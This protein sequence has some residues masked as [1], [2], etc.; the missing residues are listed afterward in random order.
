MDIGRDE[1]QARFRDMSDAELTDCAK[2]GGLT[3]LAQEVPA[4]FNAGDYAID[5]DFDPNAG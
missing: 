3:E 1:L 5:E 4:A 2:R